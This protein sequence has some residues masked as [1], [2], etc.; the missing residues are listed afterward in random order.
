[1]RTLPHMPD[2]KHPELTEIVAHLEAA[3]DRY[4][5]DLT[6][7]CA[8]DSGSY[9]KPGIDQVQSVFA[10]RLAGLGFAVEWIVNHEWGDDL[11]ARKRGSG[12]A[13]VL[14]IGHADTVYPEGEA[15]R[16]PVNVQGDQVLGPGTCDMKAGILTGIYAVEALDAIGWDGLG[17][18]TMLIVSDEEIE[19]RH[20]VETIRREGSAHDVVLTLE[21]AR[22]NGDIVTARKATRWYRIDIAGRAAHAGVEPEKGASAVLALARII[23]AAHG[24]NGH[25]RGM[26]VN[27]GRISGG[28]NPNVVAAEASVLVDI[29]AWTNKELE[30]LAAALQAIVDTEWVAGC[31]AT[32]QLN[33]GGGMPAMERS[34]GT[35]R[36][37]EHCQA[38]ASE[39]G[40]VV[41]GASTGGGSDVS[42]AVHDGAP[43]L[44]G[45]GP[46]G[47]LD[48]G[49][50]E[51]IEL[52]SIVPRT[53]LLAGLLMAIAADESLSGRTT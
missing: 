26:T 44:D 45:L 48:H 47:G 36:L 4:M 17:Q 7:V 35:V 43:G 23:D 53:A 11:I 49:P 5:A 22:A 46:I 19:Q 2:G 24:L 52:S 28:T 30:E 15:A 16:R 40:F 25:K 31:T 13:R 20:S 8:I 39:L 3:R 6:Q 18:L 51:Y 41:K 14:L 32:M 10:E 9:L 33:G 1:M 37:E 42:I 21:A 12:S 38:I 50:Y 34:P 27:A 29:R